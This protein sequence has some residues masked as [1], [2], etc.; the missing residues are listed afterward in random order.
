MAALETRKRL[1]LDTN[2]PLD[3]AAEEDFAHAF[4]E[5]FRERGYALS[6]PPTVVQE[7]TLLAFGNSGPKQEK[8]LKALQQLRQWGIEPYDLKSVGHGIT[9]QFARRLI[10]K[11]LL[12]EEEFND[13]LILAETALAH[14]PILATSDKHLLD[15]EES[16]L[17]LSFDERDLSHVAPLHP[18]RLLRAIR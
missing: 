17:K 11:R 14:I 3:L 18:K 7:L 2:I 1:A 15:I 8:A 10:Q 12:P 13:G 5:V 6:V 9:E 16:E 4:I